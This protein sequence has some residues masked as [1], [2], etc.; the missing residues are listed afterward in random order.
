MWGYLYLSHL[1]PFEGFSCFTYLVAVLF[2][3]FPIWGLV[4]YKR[5]HHKYMYINIMLCINT[6]KCKVTDT[7]IPIFLFFCKR[8]T[9]ACLSFLPRVFVW[10]SNA[11]TQGTF[12]HIVPSQQSWKGL[13][14]QGIYIL[15]WETANEQAHIELR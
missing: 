12:W 6:F 2:N 4:H 1:F 8:V 5:G 13:S 7:L 3:Y 9:S 11:G 10:H 15:V 14:S